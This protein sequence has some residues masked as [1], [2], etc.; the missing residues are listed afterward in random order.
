LTI[1]GEETTWKVVGLI[2][3][4]NNSQHD[5]FVPFDTMAKEIGNANRGAFLMAN[6]MEHTSEAQVHLIEE[7]RAVYA[8]HRLKPVFFQSAAET[9][10]QGEAQFEIVITLMLA[11]AILAAVVGG[12]G[13]MGTMSINVVERG[14]EIGVM[15]SVG[16][17]SLSVAGIFVVEGMFVGVLSWLLALPISYPGALAFSS[18]VGDAVLEMP[19]DFRF[20]IDGV[21]LWLGIVL[22]LSAVASLWPALR[23]TRVSV[24]E[25]LAY[26]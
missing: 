26:E 24:R 17:T 13:L 2:V 18:L 25:A 20:S 5:N 19:L 15:R 12:I 1:G 22:A 10:E 11:M 16:A 7:M 3:N 21:I 8:E 6:S 23:A 14:R 4:L 9:R